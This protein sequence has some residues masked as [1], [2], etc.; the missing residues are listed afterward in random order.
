[1]C[2]E[3]DAYNTWCQKWARI[4]PTTLFMLLLSTSDNQKYGRNGL[5]DLN[6]SELF[7]GY[8]PNLEKSKLA[9]C[10]IAWVLTLWTYRRSGK[11]GV[12]E[13]H[14]A[15]TSTKLKHTRFFT[16]TILLLNNHIVHASSFHSTHLC[17]L[18]ICDSNMYKAQTCA[19]IF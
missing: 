16:M 15:H 4:D 10:C 17:T 11:F 6:N 18:N 12:K 2:E 14:K 9:A 1:M 8:L 5:Q 7:P 19:L 13:L 3:A